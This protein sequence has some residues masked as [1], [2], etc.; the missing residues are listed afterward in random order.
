[1][2][3]FYKHK[4]SKDGYGWRCKSCISVESKQRRLNDPDAARKSTEAGRRFRA[5]NPGYAKEEARRRRA[6]HPEKSRAARAK[7]AKKHPQRVRD[8][9]YRRLYGITL[10]DYESMFK[11]QSGA[12]A[13][14]FEKSD[15]HLD[16]D[17]DH[18]T[19]EVRGLLCSRC[20]LLLGNVNDDCDVLENAIRYL[21]KG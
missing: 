3:A 20:N 21:M 17:H 14:C 13:V 16:V 12:C 10:E 15:K 4:S 5:A 2:L 9:K 1:V 11:K 19:G 7:Y 8:G 6:K 18:V